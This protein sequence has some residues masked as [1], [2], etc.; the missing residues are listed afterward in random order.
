MNILIT[1]PKDLIAK[2][3]SGEKRYEMRKCLPK[4]MKIKEDGFFV[5]EKGTDEVRC[6]CR[7]DDVKDTYIDRYSVR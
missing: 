5:V 3:V 6:W 4:H 2:I 7:I 1:L